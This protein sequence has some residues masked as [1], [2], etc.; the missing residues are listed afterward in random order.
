MRARLR[1]G[2][3]VTHVGV[4][5]RFQSERRRAAVAARLREAAAAA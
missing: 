1:G 4:N 2:M 5:V 3:A